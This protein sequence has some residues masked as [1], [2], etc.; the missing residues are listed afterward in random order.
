MKKSGA[1][2]RSRKLEAEYKRDAEALLSP[3]RLSN[4]KPDEEKKARRLVYYIMNG[5]IKDPDRSTE[6]SEDNLG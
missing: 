2:N 6:I 3:R 4:L 1:T 5:H